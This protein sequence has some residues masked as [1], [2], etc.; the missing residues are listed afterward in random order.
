M[1]VAIRCITRTNGITK[2]IKKNLE[3]SVSHSDDDDDDD[4]SC[5][6]I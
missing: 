6:G 2:G 1:K 3:M 5:P 4:D